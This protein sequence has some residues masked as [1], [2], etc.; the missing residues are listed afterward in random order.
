MYNVVYKRMLSC[1][2]F[3]VPTFTLHLKILFKKFPQ[4]QAGYHLVQLRWNTLT[5]ALNMQAF[6]IITQYIYTMSIS[7]IRHVIIHQTI[8]LC[9]QPIFLLIACICG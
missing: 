5:I 2:H 8:Y 9:V 3:D 4:Q 6:H 7:T 1:N